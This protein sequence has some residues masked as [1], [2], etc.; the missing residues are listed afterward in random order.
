M[1]VNKVRK[2]A[3]RK[4]PVPEPEIS[5]S[6]GR[7]ISRAGSS[8]RKKLLNA[9]E[10]LF[11]DHGYDGTSL[12]DISEASECHLALSTYHFGTKEQMFDEV[13]RR[14][15]VQLEEQRLAGLARIDLEAQP[16]AETVRLLIEAYVQPM[17]RAGHSNS[18]QW[19][20]YVRLMAG[21]VNIKRW[22]PLIQKHFDPCAQIFIAAWRK[23]QP[24]AKNDSLLNTF[25]FMVVTTL[26]TCS[27][28]NRFENWKASARAARKSDVDALTEDLIRFVHAGFMAL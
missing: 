4:A 25:S 18:V 27:Y 26:Y 16:Q 23:V 5:G 7:K 17:I 28:T 3:V 15:A 19:R 1:T 8:T 14:R 6:N 11:A 10:R 13:I 20:A 12:R 24:E 9:A 21:M 2:A 22:T